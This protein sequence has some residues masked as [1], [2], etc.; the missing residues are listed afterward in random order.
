MFAANC[1][2][3]LFFAMIHFFARYLC[4]VGC[5]SGLNALS[6]GVFLFKLKKKCLQWGG[7]GGNDEFA[8]SL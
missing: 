5:V 6:A 7:I 8:G 2:R 1:E 3:L 4:P